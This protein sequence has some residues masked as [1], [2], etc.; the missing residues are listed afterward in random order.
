DEVF[1]PISR[2]SGGER[3]RVALAKL[4]F[5]PANLLLLDEPTN[6]LD[7]GSKEVLEEALVA[8]EGSVVVASHD[9]YLLDRVATKIL[10]IDRGVARLYLGNYSAYRARKAAEAAGAVAP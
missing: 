3:S 7:V 1:K 10:E 5:Q 2:L 8:F 6:H 9:R 4:L